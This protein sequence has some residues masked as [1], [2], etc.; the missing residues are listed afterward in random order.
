MRYIDPPCCPQCESAL[1]LRPLYL[2]AGRP[3]TGLL[4]GAVGIDCPTCGIPLRVT[5]RAA[6][7]LTGAGWTLLFGLGALRLLELEPGWPGEVVAA[8]DAALAAALA[9]IVGSALGAPR[10]A[11]VRFLAAGEAAS[12]PLRAASVPAAPVRE[13]DAGDEARETGGP[14]TFASEN[15]ARDLV[16]TMVESG[17][18][19]A[20]MLNEP[21]PNENDAVIARVLDGADWVCPTC[22]ETNP[23]NFPEC[24]KCQAI[25]PELAGEGPTPPAGPSPA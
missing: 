2:R 25:R 10:L 5:A 12:F 4:R 14:R 24:W 23:G 8:T 11:R 21:P 9:F 16:V 1:D 7:M 13:A 17:N 15:E 18:D 3:L 19:P 6:A 22:H 20:E